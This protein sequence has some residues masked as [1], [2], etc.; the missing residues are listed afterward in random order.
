M[1]LSFIFSLLFTIAVGIPQDQLQ[2]IL[3]KWQLVYFDGI[4]R[5][6]NSPQYKTS[7]SAM[8]ANLDYKIKS[9]LE[10]TIYDFVSKDSLRYTD[11]VNGE[12]VV[13]NAKIELKEGNVLKIY[14]GNQVREAKIL[15]LAGNKM[16]LEPISESGGGGGKLVFERIL[17]KED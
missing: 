14:S 2:Q 16:V 12:I 15:E 8:R 10:N 1:N 11:L 3:G 7:D 9:R 6:K 17:Q 13:K 4:E 5:V